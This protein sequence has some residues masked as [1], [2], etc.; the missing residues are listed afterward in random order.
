MFKILLRRERGQQ[1]V[2]G[3]AQTRQRL[4]VFCN[5]I[6]K[7]LC[8]MLLVTHGPPNTVLEKVALPKSCAAPLNT[9]PCERLHVQLG[10]PAD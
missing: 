8:R 7:M 10:L 5:W 3:E 9:L 2:V 1:N 6:P 4:E